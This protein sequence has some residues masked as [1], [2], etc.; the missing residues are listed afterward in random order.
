M[1]IKKWLSG[2]VVK[3][4]VFTIHLFTYS[5]IHCLYCEGK[6]NLAVADFTGKNVSATD[7]SIITDLIRVTIVN[8]GIYNVVEKTHMDII[9]AEVGFQQTGCTET[10]CAVQ[11]G[12]ILN[13]EQMIVGSVSKLGETYFININIVDVE[14]A[15]ILKSEKTEAATL[16]ELANAAKE[17]A[18]IITELKP[19]EEK[20]IPIIP[21]KE[22]IKF[23]SI[24]GFYEMETNLYKK[25]EFNWNLALP[26]H[27]FQTKFWS[28]PVN[29]VDFYGQLGAKTNEPWNKKY[30]FELE[31]GWGKFAT[32]NTELLFFANEEKH[33]I[34]SPLLFLV[35]S[36]RAADKQG[37]WDLPHSVGTRFDFKDV[38][39]F[40]G[41]GI[42]ARD[43]PRRHTTGIS[44]QDE[45]EWYGNCFDI[46]GDV[47]ISQLQKKVVEIPK[48]VG[49][50]DIA[51]GYFVKRNQ[52]DKYSINKSTA[53]V[54]TG[55][56]NTARIL[57]DN[58]VISAVL[59]IDGWGASITSEFAES[60]STG[61]AAVTEN[62][63]TA[64]NC[65]LRNL[66]IGPIRLTGNYF[67]YG[68]NFRSELSYTFG[69]RPGDTDEYKNFGKTGYYT[70]ISFLVPNKLLNFTYKRTDSKT[71]FDYAYD[72][73][74][75]GSD[76]YV[77]FSSD[78][79]RTI[80]D[81]VELYA[82]FVN[83]LKGKT[84]Y[85]IKE[86]RYGRFPDAFIEVSAED[87]FAYGRLQTRLKDMNSK[88]GFGERLVY[89]G[90]LRFNLTDRLQLY[91]RAVS[92]QSN[93]LNKN[94]N[95]LFYQLR[96]NIGWDLET[97]LEYGDG[98]TTDNMAF[99]TD[100]SD[101]EREITDVVKLILKLNF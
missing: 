72:N 18:K 22:V 3:W 24:N 16:R 50:C 1:N 53:G 86:D 99:D 35:N 94:W 40:K 21:A 76:Y 65:E 95:S 88:T 34:N 44:G 26:K 46:N 27:Y 93:F 30:N 38:H 60:Y 49:S 84:G 52:F 91:L 54:I 61:T 5:L 64:L 89:A 73:Q 6:I 98:W 69:R 80:S 51:L 57:K 41:T 79:F 12:R 9:L 4:F 45:T 47:Y 55:F 14:T 36:E 28:N 17:L 58:E 67:D 32:V 42:V 101:T 90:E 66:N 59:K 20:V 13:V 87:S 70:E 81:S 11:L 23:A 62:K 48:I 10:D 43:R 85:G 77:V 29:N 96:Y 78:Y 7:A 8:T 71:R 63:D 97:Y 82:E 39:G 83:G 56:S 68:E 37:W 2:Y 31:K 74:Q 33:Y 92:V 19:A 100:I 15:K 75:I 25:S